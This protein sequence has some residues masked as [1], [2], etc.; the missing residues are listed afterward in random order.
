MDTII[1]ELLKQGL[2]GTIIV[3]L[4]AVIRLLFNKYEDSQR[5][6]IADAKA[7]Q[8]DSRRAQALIAELTPI[9]RDHTALGEDVR[10]LIRELRDRGGGRRR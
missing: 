4:L 2:P 3:V 7:S 1:P 10:E 5:E 6:R 8:E 9:L